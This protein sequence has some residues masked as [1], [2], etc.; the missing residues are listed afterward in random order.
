[1]LLT[2]TWGARGGSDSYQHPRPD[3]VLVA[4]PASDLLLLCGLVV[5]DWC[6]LWWSR[7]YPTRTPRGQ[8]H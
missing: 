3:T 4:L 2:D 8:F 5:T 7:E 1:M 6:V